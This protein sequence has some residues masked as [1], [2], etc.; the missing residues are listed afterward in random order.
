MKSV[1][2]A[3]GLDGRASYFF[4]LQAPAASVKRDTG[5][6]LARIRARNPEETK[7]KSSIERFV[8]DNVKF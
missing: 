4:A 6:D 3:D 1:S 5:R 2:T 8:S 7:G